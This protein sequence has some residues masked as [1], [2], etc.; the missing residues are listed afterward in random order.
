MGG[1]E[2]IT[3]SHKEVSLQ[4]ISEPKNSDT[5]PENREQS[6]PNASR[7]KT[8]VERIKHIIGLD[9]S[10]AFT[11]I[12]RFWVMGAGAVTLL[13]IAHFLTPAEQ[14][15]YYTFYSLVALQI[16]FELGFSYVIL[17]LSAHERATLHID[18]NDQIVGNKVAHARLASI[19]QRAVRWYSV[20]AVLM[21]LILLPI[22]IYF[23]STHQMHG[24]TVSWRMPWVLV[25]VATSL[26]FQM[27]PVFSFLEGCGLVSQVA[28]MRIGQAMLGSSLAWIALIAHHGL[29]SPAMTIIG[30]AFAGAYFILGKRKLLFGLLRHHVKEFSVSWKNEILPFQWRIAVSWFCGYFIFQLYNPVLFAYHGP[31]AAGQM[32]MSLNLANAIQSVAIAWINTK[33]APFGGMVARKEYARLDQV[34][35]RTLGQAVGVFLL[36]AIIVWCADIIFSL[37]HMHFA[38]R[39]LPPIPFSFLLIATAANV[40]VSAEAVYLR[41][42]KQEKFLINSVLGALLI[43]TST[44]FLGRYY[45]SFGMVTGNMILAI[46]FGLGVGTYTFL[47]YRRLWHEV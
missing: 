21:A 13:L 8:A 24:T 39:L 27:D 10:I 4:K 36:G 37:C 46:T 40:V 1:N 17:Q 18:E 20:A 2:E 16:V 19:L 28:R 38:Q 22:G 32:G 12:A 29:F 43:G 23:F 6:L 42:H 41:A 11:V 3:T 45:G 30:Q 34:F 44:Y 31:V 14:G 15:Y 35:F 47:K 25:V 7:I 9:R 33:N 5:S 26:T